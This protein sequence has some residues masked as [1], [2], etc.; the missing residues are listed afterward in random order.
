MNEEMSEEDFQNHY[1]HFVL[2]LQMLEK[3]CVTQC[4]I[5]DHFNVAG[6][7]H[8]EL[9]L[10]AAWVLDYRE[11]GLNP[12]QRKLINKL[13]ADVEAIP[14]NVLSGARTEIGSRQDMSHSCWVPLREQAATLLRILE[15]L[16]K[17]NADYFE[18]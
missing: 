11:S 15:P 9:L 5:G 13:V 14:E 4:Y 12:E 3:D 7:L 18:G 8:D 16:T 2:K 1:W 17:R 10:Y 6:E